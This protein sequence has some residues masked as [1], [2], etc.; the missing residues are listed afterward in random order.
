MTIE[1]AITSY[2]YLAVAFGIF[3]EGEVIVLTAGFLAQQGL[4]ELRW[5]MA[6]SVI[7]SIMTYQFYFLLGRLKGRAVLTKRPGWQ[8]R[9]ARIRS[10]L[11]RYDT[12]IIFGYRGLF[13]L[14]AITP[15]ALGMTDISHLRFTLLDLIPATIWGLGVSWAGFVLGKGAE[16]LLDNLGDY[17]LWLAGAAL[18]IGLLVISLYARHRMM[19][20]GD[21]GPL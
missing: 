16:T 12:L 4:L 17:Q 9:V 20:S 14:R 2:G 8:S 11:E 6:A 18:L 10:L 5:V 7:G 3:I 21:N 15:F 13:G 19:K 1:S